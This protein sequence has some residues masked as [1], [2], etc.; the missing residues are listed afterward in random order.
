MSKV[1][2]VV[3]FLALVGVAC[4]SDPPTSMHN[5]FVSNFQRLK[6]LKT[7]QTAD[8]SIPTS[9]PQKCWTASSN[10]HHLI[11]TE[12]S[13]ENIKLDDLNATLNEL[14]ASECIGPI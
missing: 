12:P 6:T 7:K 8:C 9:Y 14:C 2:A 13:L 5:K 4:S 11:N 3:L 1:V 10:F